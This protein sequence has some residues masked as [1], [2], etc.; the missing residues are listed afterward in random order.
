MKKKYHEEFLAGYKAGLSDPDE[1]NCHYSF[2]LT[3]ES[4]DEW[5]RGFEKGR[6]EKVKNIKING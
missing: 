3:K 5:D 2:F 6:K 1:E 4:T